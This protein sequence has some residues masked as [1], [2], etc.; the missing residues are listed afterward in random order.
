MEERTF[1]GHNRKYPWSLG[2][3]VVGKPVLIP[4]KKAGLRAAKAARMWCYRNYPS[5]SHFIR[6]RKHRDGVMISLLSKR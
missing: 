6:A 1:G 4:G 3:M 2:K 5:G